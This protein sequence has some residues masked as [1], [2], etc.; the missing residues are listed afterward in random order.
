V[1]TSLEDL[2]RKAKK[3]KEVA[4]ELN[5]FLRLHMNIWTESSTRWITTE[6]WNACGGKI[7]FQAMKGRDCYGGLDLSTSIDISAFIVVFPPKEEGERYKVLCRFWIPKENMAERVRR[8][9]VPYDVWVREGL[10][11]ATPGNVIDY[12]FII[13]EISV[14][15]QEYDLLE[16]C[17]DRWGASKIVQDLQAMG[18]E[19]EKAKYALKHLIQF[20]QGFASMAGPSAQTEKMLLGG[21]IN[22]GDNPVLSWMASNT[23]M[24]LDPAGNMKPD[25]GEST[26]R[27]DGIVSLIMAMD[28]AVQ[29]P[30]TSVYAE[31]GVLTL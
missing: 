23:V 13:N 29:E 31:R 19:D 18:F 6:K 15:A 1:C 30:P 25:K 27:I 14:L 21:E 20:G 22:H 26:E 7:D 10:I 4:T 12:N 11:T 5:N 3:A 9:R 24:K 17:Y 8:D 28:R 2:R 16:I